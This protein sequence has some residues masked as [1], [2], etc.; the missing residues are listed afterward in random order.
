MH[1]QV[2][3]ETCYDY[4]PAV[5]VAQHMAYLRPRAT[6]QQQLLAHALLVE[7]GAE[8]QGDAQDVFGNTR[9][10]ISL[11]TPHGQLRVVARSLV[12][13]TADVMPGSTVA[14]EQVRE[15]YRYHADGAYDA[16]TEFIFA[17]PYVPRHAGFAS[18]AR[19]SFLPGSSLFDAA[20]DLM[21]RIHADFRYESQST[22]VST[23][24]LEALEQRKGVCQDFAHIMVACLRSL[25]LAARYVSG[26]LLTQPGPGPARMLGGDASHAWVSV[27]LPDLP[28]ERR[29]C[30]FDPTNDRWG[31][32]APGEDY[33][34]LAI[35]RD[36]ADVSPIRG[37]IHGGA[38]HDLR[39]S[40]TVEQI[41]TIPD[42]VLRPLVQTQR[43]SQS[44]TQRG[45]SPAP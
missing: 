14:W 44:Q 24:A 16:A 23:P 29:W 36:F 13:T 32:G 35:G 19:A 2:T 20:L 1:L 26:Y 12:A 18:Y 6:A 43:Q 11:Q 31:W 9:T 8:Q 3:H 37:V 15:R 27:C 5:E 33:V 30:D 40:V 21:H 10:F 28:A 7:P 17:S 39:V 41:E 42:A 22:Q 34:V 38:Q 4:T 25:G 45:A